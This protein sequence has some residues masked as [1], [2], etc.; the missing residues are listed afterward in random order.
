MRIWII[1]LCLGLVACG[2]RSDLAPV[3]E[4]S[5]H[6]HQTTSLY[7]RVRPGETLYAVAFRYD[8]DYQ[9][10]ARYNHLRSPY[11]IRSGQVLRLVPR[12]KRM[13]ARSNSL[14]HINP[15]IS[16]AYL[17]HAPGK[18][19]FVWPVHGRLLTDFSPRQGK[20]GIEIIS[21]PVTKVRSAASGIVAYAGSGLV[22]YGN[23]ILIKH[24][25]QFLTAYGNNEKY[26]VKEGQKVVAGQVIGEVGRLKRNLYGLHFEIRHAGKPVNPL[27]YLRN[28]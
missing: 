3:T 28:R 2:P 13:R 9:Q 14:R 24:D 5:W 8:Q 27:I 6:Q 15:H 10:L 16:P 23:L 12:S 7:H 21:Q 17:E 18:M 19:H 20:K 4:L 25:N 1:A 22:G 11:A 26:F